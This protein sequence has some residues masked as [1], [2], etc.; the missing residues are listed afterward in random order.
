MK[1]QDLINNPGLG[2]QEYPTIEDVE[3]LGDSIRYPLDPEEIRA[4]IEQDKMF[5]EKAPEF[6]SRRERRG[7]AQRVS[8][9]LKAKEKDM[10]SQ[11]L[12]YDKTRLWCQNKTTEQLMEMVQAKKLDNY[13]ARQLT[14][15][16][17]A[18]DINSGE[19]LQ[20]TGM[21]N[22]D[23]NAIAHVMKGRLEQQKENTQPTI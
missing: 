12:R 5:S 14:L 4:Q 6:I 21:S 8:K 1:D 13:P 7:R 3:E 2:L 9:V 11:F 17:A 22:T 18:E 10:Q 23:R 19:N 16:Q 20:S 15:E